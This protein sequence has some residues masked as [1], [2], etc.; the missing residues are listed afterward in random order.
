HLK[1]ADAD[2]DDLPSSNQLV[3]T[4]KASSHTPELPHSG[5][6]NGDTVAPHEKPSAPETESTLAK[7]ETEGQA[8]DA[9]GDDGRMPDEGVVRNDRQGE[10]TN[11]TYGYSGGNP[12][13]VNDVY[14]PNAVSER[15]IV[16][17][18]T[19]GY[20]ESGPYPGSFK[21]PEVDNDK[22]QNIVNQMYKGDRSPTGTLG[23]GSTADAARHEFETGE[24]FKG[25]DHLNN[26]VPQLINA[27]NTWMKKNNNASKSDIHAAKE[28]IKDLENSKKGNL[29]D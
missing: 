8:S 1:H 18:N 11:S 20:Q 14:S 7:K 28:M 3:L 26:K 13:I 21:R 16:N 29:N 6:T 5:K 27:L 4:D 2:F 19:Y 12:S 23:T 10:A 25:T 22:L 24:L 15:S 9:E 17:R